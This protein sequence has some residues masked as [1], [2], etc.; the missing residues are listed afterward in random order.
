[1]NI[2]SFKQVDSIKLVPFIHV[3]VYLHLQLEQRQDIPDTTQVQFLAQLQAG[4]CIELS[5]PSKRNFQKWQ[6]VEKHMLIL[7]ISYGNE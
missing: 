4:H 7:L 1:M 2:D 6:K 5:M 3:P